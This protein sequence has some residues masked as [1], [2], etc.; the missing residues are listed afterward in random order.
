M[1]TMSTDTRGSTR[2]SSMTDLPRYRSAYRSPRSRA[3]LGTSFGEGNL[4]Y[5]VAI[6]EVSEA[7][8]EI[9]QPG[10]VDG[11]CDDDGVGGAAA[12]VSGEIE[13]GGGEVE[14][15]FETER[16]ATGDGVGLARRDRSV[17]EEEDRLHG[18]AGGG[19]EH[20][21]G[22]AADRQGLVRIAG[23]PGVVEGDSSPVDGAATAHR[24]AASVEDVEAGQERHAGVATTD[25]D[26]TTVDAR[27]ENPRD[28]VDVQV[29][30][31]A[32]RELRSRSPSERVR[33]GRDTCLRRRGETTTHGVPR[34]RDRSGGHLAAS[35]AHQR[36]AVA[37]IDDD[38]AGGVHGSAAGRVERMGGRR[39]QGID[40]VGRVLRTGDRTGAHR[41]ALETEDAHEY[42]GPGLADDG[43]HER[44]IA[45]IEAAAGRVID[46]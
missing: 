9:G 17:L 46:S 8:T 14:R 6:L 11:L 4:L 13:R 7:G 10:E 2:A 28:A 36:A 3:C 34:D 12:A 43:L 24:E 39:V 31:I 30:V 33:L 45:C 29:G 1:P 27:R 18:S 44:V 41:R 5:G 21:H 22:A 37:R 35:A 23:A 20:S 40:T 15:A 42:R 19:G 38:A 26:A 32:P 25:V 16:A